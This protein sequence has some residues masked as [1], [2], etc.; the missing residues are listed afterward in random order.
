[1][2]ALH[3]TCTEAE[4]ASYAYLVFDKVGDGLSLALDRSNIKLSTTKTP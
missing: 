4:H 3:I 1:V 2:L